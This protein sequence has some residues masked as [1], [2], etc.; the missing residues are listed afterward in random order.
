MA[1]MMILKLINPDGEIVSEE[2]TDDADR[3]VAFY[4]AAAVRNKEQ[5]LENSEAQWRHTVEFVA[6]QSE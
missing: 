6:E 5:G 1:K 3:G 2:T 4:Y